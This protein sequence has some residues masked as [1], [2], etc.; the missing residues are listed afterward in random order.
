[1]A[2]FV[3]LVLSTPAAADAI[4]TYTGNS[5]GSALPTDPSFPPVVTGQYELTDAVTGWILFSDKLVI[6]DVLI[7][8]Q[9]APTA[10]ILGYSFSDGVQTLTN[11]NSTIGFTI[12]KDISSF[13]GPLGLGSSWMFSITSS[14]GGCTNQIASSGFSGLVGDRATF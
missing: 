12:G 1:M 10:T 13:A 2:V 4:Y 9:K 8:F 7:G 11:V 14:A 3:S 5:Y 6:L